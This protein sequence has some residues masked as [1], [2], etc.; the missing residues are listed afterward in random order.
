MRD[1]EITVESMSAEWGVSRAE[2]VRRCGAV[3]NDE[4]LE[5]E[6]KLRELEKFEEKV[7]KAGFVK[8]E[9]VLEQQIAQAEK[10]VGEMSE[11]EKMRLENM[12]ER[13]A[14]LEQLDF[15]QERKEIAEERQKS[16]I[17][18]PKADVERRAPSA[19]VK[20]LKEQ[21][22][23]VSQEQTQVR[24]TWWVSPQW[25]GQWLPINGYDCGVSQVLKIDQDSIRG[26]KMEEN[27]VVCTVPRGVLQLG[28][29]LEQHRKIHNNHAALESVAAELEELVLETPGRT[30]DDTLLSKLEMASESVV[31]S[32]TVTSMDTCW[33]FVGFGTA[34]GG[35]GVQIAAN[36]IRWRPHNAEVTG[37]AFCGGSSDLSILSVSLDGAVRRSNLACQSVLL[38]YEEEEEGIGCL[39]KRNQSEFLL[40]CDSTVRLI[41]LR[42]RKVSSLLQQ[43]GSKISLH[44]TDPHM[45]TVGASIY[46][47]RQPKNAL[48]ALPGQVSSL[49]WSPS[50]GK[51]VLA[52]ENCAGGVRWTSPYSNWRAKVFSTEQ[53]VRGESGLLLTKGVAEPLAAQWNPWVKGSLLLSDPRRTTGRLR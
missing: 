47:L 22:S 41:D 50:S 33:D 4:E 20:A 15:D 18:T 45:L 24:R 30:C 39:V 49:Q 25:V 23:R 6:R 46:D 51:L 44:P 36:N 17:F 10:R 48:L 14:L 16:M 43:G 11:Y 28:E 5:D 34:D 40:G 9:S 7:Q 38:E 2:V 13:Q 35:V 26:R 32:S 42:R 12:K 21:K 53:L 52:I 37:I 3:K 8:K 29:I 19:R 27:E 1:R 31:A